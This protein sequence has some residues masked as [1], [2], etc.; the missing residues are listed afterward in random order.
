MFKYLLT[1]SSLLILLSC[2]TDGLEDFITINEP[3]P[4]I[5]NTSIVT[6]SFTIILTANEGGVVSG[7]GTFQKYVFA[8]ISA[9]PNSGFQFSSWSDG[10]TNQTRTINVTQDLNL[11]ANFTAVTGNF[12]LTVN[13]QAGGTVSSSGGTY[14]EGAEITLTASPND[15]YAFVS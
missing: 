14:E 2:T 10:S 8:I 11:T 7:G 9:T 13:S 15:G 1:F 5:P 6:P 12:T 3:E 4:M